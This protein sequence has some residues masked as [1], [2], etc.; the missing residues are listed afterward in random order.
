MAPTLEGAERL[1]DRLADVSPGSTVGIGRTAYFVY[2]R[3][4]R[5]AMAVPE[6]WEK[7]PVVTKV[8]GKI[9]PAKVS[10]PRV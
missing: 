3:T 8:V 4:R 10:A 2:A 6:E 9:R 5:A 1:A 7:V